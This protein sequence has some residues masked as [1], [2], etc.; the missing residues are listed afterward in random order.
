MKKGFRQS[1]ELFQVGKYDKAGHWK[2]LG[3]PLRQWIL[4]VDSLDARRSSE[5]ALNQLASDKIMSYLDDD[6]YCSFNGG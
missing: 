6:S 5:D 1:S 2:L 4:K 3:R